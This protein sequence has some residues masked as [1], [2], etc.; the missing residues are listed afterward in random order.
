MNILALSYMMPPMRSPQAIQVGRLLVHLPDT[1]AVVCGASDPKGY[2]DA[3]RE[4]LRKCFAHLLE[5]PFR[6][7]LQGVWN[8]LAKR[9]IPAY[10]VRPDEYRGWIPKALEAIDSFIKT[11][12]FKPDVLVSFGEPMSDHLLGL[13][14]KRRQ[15]WPWVAHFSDPWADCSYRR[16]FWFSAPA[17]KRMERDVI[18]QADG[19]VFTSPQTRSLVMGNYPLVPYEKTWILPHSFEDQNFAKRSENLEEGRP[20]IVRHLGNFFGHRLPYPLLRGL[21]WLKKHQPS[22]LSNVRFELIGHLSR[23][24][25]WHPSFWGLPEGLLRLRGPVPY[26]DSLTL[27]RE[28]DLLIVIDGL[29][30]WNVFFPSKLADYIGACRPIIG[31]TPPGASADVISALGGAVATPSNILAVSQVLVKGLHWAK[32]GRTSGQTSWRDS[33]HRDSFRAAG[34]AGSFS[35]W[36]RSVLGAQTKEGKGL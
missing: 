23:L 12:G 5:V 4:E 9:C 14:L 25:R 20:L 26:A 1:V 10:G 27:M 8:R 33:R 31:I 7:S 24:R 15:S 18:S 22:V 17:N 21:Q 36:L 30:S 11:S 28:A 29:E 34:V 3:S 2:R 19:L 6:P 35:L 32:L 16:P 13:E